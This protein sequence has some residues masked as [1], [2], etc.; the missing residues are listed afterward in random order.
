M[1]VIKEI[2][3]LHGGSLALTSDFGVGTTV[4]MWLPQAVS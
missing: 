3:E 2:V 1:S 4:T